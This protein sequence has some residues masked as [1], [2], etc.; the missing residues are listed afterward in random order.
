[1][2]LLNDFPPIRCE[3]IYEQPVPMPPAYV[4]MRREMTPDGPVFV[5]D[6]AHWMT[7][8]QCNFSLS[9]NSTE[10]RRCED[11]GPYKEEIP[12][13]WGVRTPRFVNW[14]RPAATMPF[15]KLVGVIQRAFPKGSRIRILHHRHDSV[16]SEVARQLVLT[17]SSWNGLGHNYILA[18]VYIGNAALA[19]A[20][21][22]KNR[23]STST[24]RVQDA[25]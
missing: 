7:T 6:C 22:W 8:P 13:E 3:P 25:W 11:L 21:C 9:L 5:A 17:T 18:V 23:Q 24:N 10:G 4:A 14:V 15:R 12:E 16:G 20:V 19:L 2:H 1:M